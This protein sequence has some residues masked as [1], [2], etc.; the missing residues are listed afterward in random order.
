MDGTAIGPNSITEPHYGP[1]L[2]SER[3]L[4][5]PDAEEKRGIDKVECIDS[6][7]TSLLQ[8]FQYRMMEEYFLLG[9]VPVLG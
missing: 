9:N 8:L 4:R 5:E 7:L 6:V 1:D 2:N 3:E